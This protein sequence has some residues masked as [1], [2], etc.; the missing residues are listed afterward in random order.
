MSFTLATSM[1]IVAKAGLNVD[2]A[3]A[4]SGALI[5]GFCDES[6]ALLF[7][8]TG[9]DFVTNYANVNPNAKPFLSELV[10]SHS[11]MMLINANHRAY[12]A[13]AIAQVMLDTLDEKFQRGIALITDKEGVKKLL[14]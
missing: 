10:S 9:Y 8:M 12:G 3:I 4:T 5:A 14:I 2:N 1:A 7:A 11:A 6:E 13:K